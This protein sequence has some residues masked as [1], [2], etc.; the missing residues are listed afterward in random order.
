MGTRRRRRR[1]QSRRRPMTPPR[2]RRR[3]R[4]R[5]AKS[6]R[7][8]QLG[9]GSPSW[10]AGMAAGEIAEMESLYK[11]LMSATSNASPSQADLTKKIMRYNQLAIKVG[12]T[13]R[14]CNRTQDRTQV[15]SNTAQPVYDSIATKMIAEPSQGPPIRHGRRRGSVTSSAGSDGSDGSDG[16]SA[17][18]STGSN[19]SSAVSAVSEPGRDPIGFTVPVS[20]SGSVPGS[21]SGFTVDTAPDTPQ[22]SKKDKITAGMRRASQ[23]LRRA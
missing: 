11:L 6:P 17:P 12:E 4:T 8:R 16:S 1:S 15:H 22:P 19:V 10:N 14:F 2:S 23:S 7:R 13:N 3:Q 5:R 18:S 9:R 21:D 20:V